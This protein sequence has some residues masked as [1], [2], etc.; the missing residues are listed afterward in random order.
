MYLKPFN[1]SE[2]NASET[3]RVRMI[4]DCKSIVLLR[5]RVQGEKLMR[6]S[7]ELPKQKQKKEKKICLTMENRLLCHWCTSKLCPCA[8]YSNDRSNR[9]KKKYFGHFDHSTPFLGFVESVLNVVIE[10]EGGGG[11]IG[12]IIFVARKTRAIL[13]IT[14]LIL[15]LLRIN[16]LIRE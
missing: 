16:S 12:E 2:S 9:G 10:R 8:F 15:F 11:G 4:D 14:S 3:P 5:Q 13:T 1:Y 7:W 6:S